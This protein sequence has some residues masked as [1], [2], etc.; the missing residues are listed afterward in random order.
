MQQNAGIAVSNSRMCWSAQGLACSIAAR[1]GV[2]AVQPCRA[3]SKS[4]PV[5][6]ALHNHCSASAML[7]LVAGILTSRR[8]VIMLRTT[9]RTGHSTT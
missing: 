2:L 5:G 4:L 9:C 3:S 8:G 6:S 1:A 7:I